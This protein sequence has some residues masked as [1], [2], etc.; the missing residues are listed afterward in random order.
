MLIILWV[1]PKMRSIVL[2][3]TSYAYYR[4]WEFVDPLPFQST[5]HKYWCHLYSNIM[6]DLKKLAIDGLFM[7]YLNIVADDL[8]QKITG[9]LKL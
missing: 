6:Q 8:Y 2:S 4:T 7:M 5:N 9:K 1:G 3:N